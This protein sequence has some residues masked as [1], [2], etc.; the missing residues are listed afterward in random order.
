MRRPSVSNACASAS[1][2]RSRLIVRSPA[3]RW[4]D[5]R[6]ERRVRRVLFVE[7][8]RP[9]PAPGSRCRAGPRDRPS[10]CSARR[11]RSRTGRAPCPRRTPGSAA[12]RLAA[13]RPAAASRCRLTRTRAVRRWRRRTSGRANT[14]GKI[15]RICRR[16]CKCDTIAATAQVR[17]TT[18]PTR[19]DGCTQRCARATASRGLHIGKRELVDAAA[20]CGA[21]ARKRARIDDRRVAP[22]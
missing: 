1:A 19:A 12:G 11:G 14:I 18:L 3:C 6:V 4:V 2:T 16:S 10:S 21:R 15:D 9:L 17:G 8:A 20:R 7:A 22:R 13:V 5:P